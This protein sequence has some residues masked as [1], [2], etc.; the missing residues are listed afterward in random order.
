MII[1]KYL[2]IFCLFSVLGWILELVYRSIITKTIVNPG[3]MTGCVLPIYGFGAVIMNIICTLV[4]NSNSN[5]KGII[6]LLLSFVLLSLLEFISGYILLKFFHLRLWDY[7]SRKFNIKGFICPLF[8]IIWTLLAFLYYHFIYSWV[9]NF[10]STFV[11]NSFCL[12]SLGMFVGVFLID[13]FISIDLLKKLNIYAQSL[14]QTISIEKIKMDS[15]KYSTRKKLWK[16]IY[17]YISTN[18]FLKEK[19]KKQ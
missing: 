15:I 2:F 5:Y 6:I 17:P 19:T 14:K 11:K 3:F 8:S 7:S 12:F 18:K 13:L 10:S 1:L 4:S 9:N 16:A